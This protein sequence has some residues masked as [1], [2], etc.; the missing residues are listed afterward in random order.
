MV[1]CETPIQYCLVYMKIHAGHVVVCSYCD[2]HEFSFQPYHYI[3]MYLLERYNR[4]AQGLKSGW[5]DKDDGNL[6]LTG[7][8][9]LIRDTKK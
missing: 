7:P 3:I 5:F 2:I 8:L 4:Q 6:I 9:S 1:L